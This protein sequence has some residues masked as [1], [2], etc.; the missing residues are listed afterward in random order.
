M[1]L[2]DNIT[3]NFDKTLTL[4]FSLK[5]IWII[6]PFVKSDS[7][8]HRLQAESTDKA[9]SVLNINLQASKYNR[10]GLFTFT[11]YRLCFIELKLAGYLNLMFHE[12]YWILD[13]PG[14]LTS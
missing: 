9:P 14:F 6:Q 12:T 13:E 3:E 10:A 7:L 5:T 4:I 2:I 8:G 11:I 1:I